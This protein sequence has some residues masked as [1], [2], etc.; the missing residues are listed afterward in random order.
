MS[1]GCGEG[2]DN[3]LTAP[4]SSIPSVAG[5]YSGTATVS[6]PGG[7]VTCP[8]TTSVTQGTGGNVSIAPMQLGG[9]C[10]FSVPVGDATIGPTGS[11]GSVNG[12]VTANGCVY[13]AVG[14][15]GFFGN[16]LR[17][18]LAYTVAN[19]SANCFS[20]TVAFTLNRQ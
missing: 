3:N 17:I 18:S 7:Q 4:S 15:G 9:V 13:N 20:F 11:L 5:N 16:E 6:G 19:P 2:G 8:T 10:A 1:I 14:S 12:S